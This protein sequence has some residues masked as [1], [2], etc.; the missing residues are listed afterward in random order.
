MKA[1]DLRGK[2]Q[3]ELNKELLGL[4]REQ[5]NLRM[6][7]ATGQLARPHEYGRVKKDIAR[8]KTILGELRQASKS[9]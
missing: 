7:R 5:F 6:Q 2:S 8:V 3:E 4:R 1:V 9:E